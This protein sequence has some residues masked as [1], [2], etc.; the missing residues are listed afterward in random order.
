MEDPGYDHEGTGDVSGYV[1]SA[2]GRTE[3]AQVALCRTCAGGAGY[4]L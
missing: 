3:G 2:Q 1:H 4:L